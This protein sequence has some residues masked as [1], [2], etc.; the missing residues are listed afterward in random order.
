[1]KEEY[2]RIAE[3]AAEV[4]REDEGKGDVKYVHLGLEQFA[5]LSRLLHRVG[6]LSSKWIE[7]EK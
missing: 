1:M 2:E 5:E 4:V 6:A 7:E 3:L